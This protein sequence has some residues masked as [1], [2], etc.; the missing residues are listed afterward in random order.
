MLSLAII[1]FPEFANY[2]PK[3]KRNILTYSYVEPN[4]FL[5]RYKGENYFREKYL[6]L[7]SL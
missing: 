1:E 3:K 5:S 7:L 2:A 6:F 4:C